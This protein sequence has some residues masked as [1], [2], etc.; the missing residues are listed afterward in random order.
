MMGSEASLLWMLGETARYCYGLGYTTA[1]EVVSKRV[2]WHGLAPAITVDGPLLAL[3][4]SGR[5]S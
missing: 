2:R 5:K 1:V 4:L 3:L